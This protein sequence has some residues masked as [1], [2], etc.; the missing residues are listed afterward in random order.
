M[1]GLI[2]PIIL[3]A[4]IALAAVLVVRT[5]RFKAA[6]AGTK[7]SAPASTKK[8][9][10]AGTEKSAPMEEDTKGAR[11]LSEAV[12]IRTISYS[13]SEKTDFG[14]FLSFHA[15]ME[16][17]FPAFHKACEKTVVNGYSL[18]YRWPGSPG[19]KPVLVTAHMDV[20]PVEPGTEEDWEKDPFGGEISGGRVWGRGTLDT[21]VHIVAALEAAERLIQAGFIPSRDVWFAFGHDEEPG[22]EQ[23]AKKIADYF[24]KKGLDFEFVLDEG[25]CLVDGAVAGVDKPVAFVGVGEKGYANIRLTAKGDGGHSSMP[26]KHSSLGILA[27]ALCRLEAKPCRPRLIKPVREFLLRVGPEMGLLN[28]VILANLWLLKPLFL[29]V[30]SKTRSGSAMT[31]TTTAVTMAEGSPAPNVMPQKSTAVVNFRIIPGETGK[32]LLNHIE[33]ALKGLDVTAEPLTL[34]EP[35]AISPSGTEGYRLIEKLTLELYPGAVVTPYLVMASTDAR[36]Y[37]PVSRHIYRF[38]PYRIMNEELSKMHGTNE[39]I[40]VENVGRCI[41]FFKKLFTEC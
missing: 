20:V 10:P 32:D 1:T 12:K 40:T 37:E 2:L 25:G 36:K 18:V 34:D 19:K 24:A 4:I 41:A 30:F 3:L 6:P 35:S 33:D 26:G 22:G 14:A 27:Q 31:R 38:T 28:R 13:D 15:L 16:K 23:G 5:A 39:N 21:K 11:K 9:A 8:S 29:S 7:K 17:L